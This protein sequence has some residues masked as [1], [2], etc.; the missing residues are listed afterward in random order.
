MAG[1]DL[2]IKAIR[3]QVGSAINVLVQV[4][5][6]TDGSRKVT[7]I[8]EIVG[9]EG[10]QIQLQDIFDFVQTGIAPDGRVQGQFRASGL[11]TKFF[12]RLVAAGVKPQDILCEPGKM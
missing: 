3:Q 7:K 1:Y 10:D 8:S 2:P 6:L 12:D 4:A 9:L 11:R 5:R